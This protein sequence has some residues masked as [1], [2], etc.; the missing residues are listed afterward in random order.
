MRPRSGALFRGLGATGVYKCPLYCSCWGL[1]LGFSSPCTSDLYPTRFAQKASRPII[2][3]VAIH[4]SA[5]RADLT[6]RLQ[7]A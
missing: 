5:S 3:A 1:A 7:S 6:G 2:G 4:A